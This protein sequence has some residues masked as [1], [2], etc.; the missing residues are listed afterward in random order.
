[1][2]VF[3]KLGVLLLLFII[4][5][6]TNADEK[7]TSPNGNSI[8]FSQKKE[9]RHVEPYS[10][11]KLTFIKGGKTFDI[12]RKDRTYTEDGLFKLSPSGN[13]LVVNSISGDYVNSGNGEKKYVDRAYCSVIDMSDGCVVSDWDGEACSYNWA[14]DR[15]DLTK[16][17]D[18]QGGHFDFVS[19]KPKMTI[20]VDPL[21][22]TLYEINN[23]LR[24]DAPNKNNINEYQMLLNVNPLAKNNV[25]VALLS[26]LNS[27]QEKIILNRKTLL[28]S[29]PNENALMKSYLISGDELAVIK[30]SADEKWINVG[31]INSKGIPLIIWIKKED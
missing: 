14:K 16:H 1:M 24:C 31:Y 7:I 15:D 26:F 12:S 28:Y 2:S 11:G 8:V 13:Y 27:L 4:P 30:G 20:L 18:G 22:F 10:W 21:S 6:V 29:S 9:G 19:Y 23:L 25:S 17:P 3:N 5:G